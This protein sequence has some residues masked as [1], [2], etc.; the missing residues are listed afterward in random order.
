MVNK[1]FFRELMDTKNYF[2]SCMSG[3]ELSE[4]EYSELQKRYQLCLLLEGYVNSCR[5]CDTA[6]MH[7]MVYNIN[8]PAP[9]VALESNVSSNTVR[10]VRSQASSKLYS[11]FSRDIF[12]QLKFGSKND[13]EK[14]RINMTILL[15]GYISPEVFIPGELLNSMFK[16]LPTDESEKF[17][18]K[19]C[20]EVLSFLAH[21]DLIK[22]HEAFEALDKRKLRYIFELLSQCDKDLECNPA[23]LNALAYIILN[24]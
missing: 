7:S 3:S 5:W 12:E 20:R 13:L 23:K 11:I 4:S 8:R 24:Y 14:V 18:L 10:S 17:S 19:D 15:K 9:E 21:Y 1:L 2:V 22:M 16:T 6:K